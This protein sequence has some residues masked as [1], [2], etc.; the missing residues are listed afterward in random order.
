MLNPGDAV[1]IDGTRCAHPEFI[2]QYFSPL[3]VHREV[4]I[5]TILYVW[6]QP[7][8]GFAS[9]QVTEQENGLISPR[10]ALS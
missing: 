4:V 1:D 8:S 3:P 9:D 7:Q 5:I 2:F 10:P 6:K